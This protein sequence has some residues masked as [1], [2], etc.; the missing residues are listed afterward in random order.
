MKKL[1][2]LLFVLLL[3]G[4]LYAQVNVT[5]RI[6]TATHPDTITAD[7]GFIELRG[8]LNT[9]A[10]NT[11][12]DGNTIDWN[13]GSTLHLTNVGG[14]YW[15]VTFQMNPQDTLYYKAWTGFYNDASVGT[16]PGGGW[17]GPF[18]VSN[19]LTWD[20]RT[21]ISGDQDTV[22]AM[23]YY[24]YDDGNGGKVDQYA[25]PFE[26]K[27]DS[28]AVY[29]RVS[30]GGPMES[31]SFDPATD[32][33]V[34]RGAPE[35]SG[36]SLDWGA[37][38][39]TLTRETDSQYDGSFYS[40]VGY[41]DM[42]SV[43]AGATQE[44]KFVFIKN[45]GDNWESTPN[46][47]FTY[48]VGLKDTTIAW[49]FYNDQKPTGK[50]T[51]T[52]IITFRVSTEAL[53]GIGLFD[54]GKGDYIEVRGPKGWDATQ[55][56]QLAYNP[57]LQE[58][59]STNEE[60]TNQ[61]GA[62]IVYKYYVGWDSSRIDSTSP[63][64]IPNLNIG[65]GWEEPAVT[66]GGNRSHIF[67]KT[68]QS[69]E[70]DFGFQRQFF[71]GVPA[72]AVIDHDISIHFSIDMTNAANADS[73]SLGDPFVPGDT[74]WAFWDG[75]L[76]GWSQGTDM[77]YDDTQD[78]RFLELT[79]GDGNMVYEG[80]VDLKVDPPTFPA[81]WYQLGYR[82]AYKTAA[83]DIIRNGTGGAVRGRRYYQ[84]IHPSEILPD[85]PDLDNLPETVWPTSYTLPT[86]KWT[87][88]DLYVEE[89]PNLTQATVSV[90]KDY[91]PYKFELKQNYPNPFNPTTTITYSLAKKSDVKIT[92]YN[93]M[94]QEVRTLINGNMNAGL[95]E[96]VWNGRNN[97][98]QKVASGVYLCKMVA[99][100]FEQTRKMV[101]IR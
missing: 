21:F 54:R 91:L 92:I 24:H 50:E 81:I 99:G 43:A 17:E 13:S 75:E 83:G 45:G 7:N 90:G 88:G 8:A 59:T 29:F 56:V 9:V 32:M 97:T 6:N 69:V 85:G 11:L 19:G 14:D 57:L 12:P 87:D 63:N 33:V 35:T 20:T 61:E 95:F 18:N 77:W 42:D 98:N 2:I 38:R 62:E 26:H 66:G 40:G 58:W 76:T 65:Q 94:G 60:F 86:L 72:N 100:D 55:A 74:V 79:D 30:M 93:M 80:T 48:P 25:A 44:H 28:V 47:P 16:A 78:S 49:V 53:K 96:L 71:N 15:E 1:S 27:A 68:N 5:V 52:N 67:Q 41:F 3:S 22:L 36:G 73:N 31:L 46:R 101:L 51:Y 37:N 4:F 82:V 84:Y 64:F 34:V 89:P 70:G 39:V 23:Q 10:P